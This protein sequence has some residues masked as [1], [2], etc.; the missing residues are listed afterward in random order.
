MNFRFP[1]F[2]IDEDSR[3]ENASGLG[4][5]AMAE[6]FEKEGCEV[7]GMTSYGDL[8]QFAQQQS[9][10]KSRAFGDSQWRSRHCAAGVLLQHEIR[11]TDG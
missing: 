4:I 2:I 5:R 3:S 7:V 8:S 9:R 6:A 11:Q 10:G 1:I